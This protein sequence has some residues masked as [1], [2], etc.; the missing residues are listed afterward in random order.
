MRAMHVIDVKEHQRIINELKQQHDAEKRT[1]AEEYTKKL[2]MVES[3]IDEYLKRFIKI[4]ILIPNDAVTFRT[5]V[6]LESFITQQF[7]VHGD[8]KH[9]IEVIGRRIA[10]M[11]ERDLLS[12]NFVRYKSVSSSDRY[13]IRKTKV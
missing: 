12:C 13:D 2:R 7:M 11:V 5:V 4:D 6:E 10:D 8:D 9:L 3:K 1:L